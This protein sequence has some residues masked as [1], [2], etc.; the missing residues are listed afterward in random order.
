MN[1][2]KI[3]ICLNGQNLLIDK[4]TKIE[5]LVRGKKGKKDSL[6]VAALVNNEIK[7]L[8]YSKLQV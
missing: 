2:D 1:N 7:E 4:G 5:E 3:N 6:I 8:T